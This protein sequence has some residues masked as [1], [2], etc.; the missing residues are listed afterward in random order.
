MIVIVDEH[1][2]TA[3]IVTLEDV[4][5]EI[6]GHEIVDEFDE[7]DDMRAVAQER[8]DS[9]LKDQGDWGRPGS[10]D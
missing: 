5:E 3:G 9:L 6:L 2:G 1:G 10:K 4:L 8:R 7:V